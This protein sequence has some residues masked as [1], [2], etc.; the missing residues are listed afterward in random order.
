MLLPICWVKPLLGG[1]TFRWFFPDTRYETENKNGSRTVG[2]LNLVLAD[3]LFLKE[4]TMFKVK[5]VPNRFQKVTVQ[6]RTQTLQGW[7]GGKFFSAVWASV[8]SKIKGGGGGRRDPPMLFDNKTSSMSTLSSMSNHD[9][10]TEEKTSKKVT[11]KK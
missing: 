5:I 8:C 2:S 4:L 9:G 1:F 10:S 7:G 3:T 11:L 6:C